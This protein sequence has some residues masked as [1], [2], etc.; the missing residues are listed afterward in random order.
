MQRGPG[1]LL[2]SNCR[3]LAAQFEASAGMWEDVESLSKA[4]QMAL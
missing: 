2:N 3:R 4:A 1:D